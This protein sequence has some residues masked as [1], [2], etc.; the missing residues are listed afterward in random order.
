MI[1][2][3]LIGIR[4]KSKMI[5]QKKFLDYFIYKVDSVFSHSPQGGSIQFCENC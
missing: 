4:V 5:K 1:L 2:T 3:R